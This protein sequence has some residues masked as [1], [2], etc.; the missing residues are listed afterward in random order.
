MSELGAPRDIVADRV[1]SGLDMPRVA[2]VQVDG[3]KCWVSRAELMG[4]ATAEMA[5]AMVVT[6]ALARPSMNL[7]AGVYSAMTPDEARRMAESLLRSAELA[8]QP[9]AGVKGA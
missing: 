9:F 3:V 8:E 6:V 4:V 2:C 1:D 5:G 7:M